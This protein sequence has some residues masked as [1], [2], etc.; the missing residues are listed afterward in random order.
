MNTDKKTSKIK[1]GIISVITAIFIWTAITYINPP[2]LTTTISNLPV[3]FAGEE[4]LRERGL[5]VVDRS[6]ITGLSVTVEGRRDTLLSLSGG[7]F[8]EVDVSSVTEAGE[9]DL[10]GNVTLPSQALSIDDVKFDTVPVT[11]DKIAVKEIPIRAVQTGSSENRLVKTV[12]LDET[13]VLTGAKSEI[14]AVSYGEAAADITGLTENSEV[15]T[16]YV[17][18]DDSGTPI[19]S[20]ETISATKTKVRISC[21]VYDAVTLPVRAELSEEM[22]KDYEIDRSGVS[23]TP[24]TVEI[25]LKDI[26]VSEVTA[27][28]TDAKGSGDY[29]LEEKSNMYIPDN[30]KTVRVRADIEKR[31][32]KNVT[33][34]VKPENLADGFSAQIGKISVSASGIEKN[35]VPEK[36]NAAVDLSGLGKGTYT[37]PVSI[38][39]VD[40]QV[41]GSYTASVTIN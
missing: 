21:E 39:S 33:I 15:E 14:E 17:L 12:P 7:I 38:S 26:G 31:V 9:Y 28:I 2:E 34:D 27:L 36:I 30:V 25:G 40:A 4:E 35:L 10:A 6:G 11:V 18:M 1:M 8:V 3:R 24:S 23:I 29:T 37:L 22:A 16:G 32:S 20:N 5:T 19:T 13:V 41:T